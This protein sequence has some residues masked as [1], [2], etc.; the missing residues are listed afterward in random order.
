M[1]RIVQILVVRMYET[2]E[3]TTFYVRLVTDEGFHTEPCAHRTGSAYME[4]GVRVEVP[5]LSLDDA[6]QRA[7]TDAGD[8]ADLL[9]IPM[10]P[11]VEDGVEHKAVWDRN[12]FSMEREIV[13]R[14]A[15][16]ADAAPDA[17][18]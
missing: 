16:R 12:R 13:R 5:G 3:R 4:D 15:A 17:E 11:Y 1:R 18:D 9:Q 2:C 10:D 14:R 6:R 8:W 7:L